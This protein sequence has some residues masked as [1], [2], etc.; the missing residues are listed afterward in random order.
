MIF[1]RKCIDILSILLFIDLAGFRNQANF[2]G[3][4]YASLH[5]LC[6]AGGLGPAEMLLLYAFRGKDGQVRG[7]S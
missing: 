5:G 3:D 2:H 1:S 6:R 4:M 7:T